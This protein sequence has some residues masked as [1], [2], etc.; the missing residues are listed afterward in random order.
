VSA[1]SEIRVLF[2]EDDDVDVELELDALREGGL[3]PRHHAVGSGAELRAA[4]EGE[5]WDVVICAYDMPGLSGLEALAIARAIAPATPFILVSARGGESVA[6]DAM[7][8]GAD[9]YVLKE[10][11]PRL[12]SAVHRGRRDAERK[13]AGLVSEKALRLLA[14]AGVALGRSLERD[15]IVKEVPALAVRDFG[16][17]CA[18][19]LVDDDGRFRRVAY[20]HADAAKADLLARLEAEHADD[21]AERA[22]HEIARGL[23]LPATVSLPVVS[24][25]KVVGAIDLARRE[26][27]TPLEVRVIDELA[28]RVAVA[29]ENA[30]LYARAQQ[31]VQSRDEFLSIA[32][33]E[34]RTPLTALQLHIQGLQE[35][36]RKQ[37]PGWA[38]ER[39]LRRLRR[40]A[41]ALGRLGQLVEELLDVSRISSGSLELTREP[42]DLAAL[43]REVVGRSDDEAR[44]AGC[45]L[46]LEVSGPVVG[47][48]DRGR[49]EQVL[50]SLLSNAMKYGAGRPVE[51]EVEAVD[52][53]ALLR[54]VDHGIGV[55]PGDADRI[56]GRFERAAPS[57]HY[58]GLGLGLF[59]TRHIVE[60]HGGSVGATTTPAGGATFTVSLPR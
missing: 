1:P 59:L 49:L 57:R 58:G 37:Q 31:A 2:V 29:L 14:D 12:A 53:M 25:G 40:S 20:A 44:H 10:N 46:V 4:L 22:F 33:H 11:L 36:A 42:V 47:D 27:Y 38:D 7:R 50:A 30:S 41:R 45:G 3:V 18:I 13:R 16:E 6:V 43:A 21:G 60:A 15:A 9:D 52:G 5:A 48:W 55:P 26:P 51:V 8:G 28:G 24:E 32:S 17:V 56:F 19:E 23:G 34:L 54:V 39:L 35:L